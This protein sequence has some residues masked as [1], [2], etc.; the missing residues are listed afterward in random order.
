MK[1]VNYLNYFFVGVPALLILLGLLDNRSF[2]FLIG[3][4][5]LFSILTGLFQ[6]TIGG[7]MLLE[8]PRNKNLQLYIIGV[9]LY[10]TFLCFNP[11]SNHDFKTYFLLGTPAL[12]AFY[13][14]ILIY[15]KA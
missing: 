14:S 13:L 2:G 5:L 3:Y 9:F 15:K 11:F 1:N 12:L 4:G 7:C 10:F 6:L 8:E